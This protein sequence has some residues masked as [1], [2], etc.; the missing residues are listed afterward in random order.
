MEDRPTTSTTSPAPP[1]ATLTESASAAL[2]DLTE[3]APRLPGDASLNASILDRLA[4]ELAEAGAMLRA[5]PGRPAAMTGHA[6]AALAAFR[7]SI[8]AGEDIGEFIATTLA[9]L[10][11]EVGGTAAVIAN[12]LGSGEAGIVADLLSGTAGPYDEGLPAFGA[13]S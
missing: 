6:Y 12:R 1:E 10:A 9:R 4:E 2:A 13:G 8:D 7:S 3:L 5:L 11:A